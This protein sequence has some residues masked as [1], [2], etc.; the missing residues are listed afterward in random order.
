MTKKVYENRFAINEEKL[1]NSDAH[2]FIFRFK[3]LFLL[4]FFSFN[5]TLILAC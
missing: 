3:V 2:N 5:E 1:T 4:L